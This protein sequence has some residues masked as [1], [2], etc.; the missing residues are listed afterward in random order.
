MLLATIDHMEKDEDKEFIL[1]LYYKYNK[2][3]YKKIWDKIGSNDDIDD[4]VN[5]TFLKLI[6]KVEIL[7]GLGERELLFYIIQ[8]S[9]HMSIDYI[10]KSSIRSKHLYYGQDGDM[11]DEISE[12]HEDPYTYDERI[13][14]LAKAIQMLPERDSSI[15]INKYY[16]NKTD[17][18][19]A[20]E[21]GIHVKSVRQYLTRA[22]R[23]ARMLMEK[24]CGKNE[25]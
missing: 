8:T 21:I 15:L 13:E 19:I 18:E 9:S 2:L 7:K 4:I 20:D 14:D 12:L 16:F 17:K 25:K 10:R 11:Q 24:E 5:D 6:E 23:R 22:R 1:T 3:V